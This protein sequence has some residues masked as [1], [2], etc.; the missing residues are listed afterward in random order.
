VKKA[1]RV[2]I[3]DD[4]GLVRDGLVALLREHGDISV[5]GTAADGHEALEAARRAKPDVVVMDIV[6]PRLNGIDATTLLLEAYPS[7]CVV[8]V[9]AHSN[10]QFVYRALRAGALGYVTKMAVAAHL[11][12]S[13]R[14]VVT[15]RRFLSP[16]IAESVLDDYVLSRSPISPLEHLSVRERQ[17]L[18]M[19]AE[20]RSSVAIAG[21]LSLSPKTIDTY[22]SRMMQKL[23]ITELPALVKFAIQHGITPPE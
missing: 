3:A 5:V 8:I 18:Q 14:T 19:I 22:R 16:D 1:T 2:L 20:G 12:E 10:I 6:M 4:H 9:S 17:I 15:G 13:V 11:V 21:A 23:G 7:I